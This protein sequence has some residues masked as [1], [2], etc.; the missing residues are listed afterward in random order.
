MTVWVAVLG[1]AAGCYALKLAGLAAPQ[2]LLDRPVVRRFVELVPVALLGALIA[3]QTVSSNRALVLD[4][5]SAG[6]A[7][8]VVAVLLR[9]PFVLVVVLAVVAAALVRLAAG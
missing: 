8:A 4:A 1:G 7:V 6:L 5:R 2:R 3:V 9:A